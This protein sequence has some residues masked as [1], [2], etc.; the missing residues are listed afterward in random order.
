[1]IE[2]K[3]QSLRIVKLTR[4]NLNQF[5]SILLEE[6]KTGEKLIW[7]NNECFFF[8]SFFSI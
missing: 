8:F 2:A 5:H 1:M 7:K 4:W 3:K 6:K